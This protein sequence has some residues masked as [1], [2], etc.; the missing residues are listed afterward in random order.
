MSTSTLQQKK[1]GLNSKDICTI[2]GVLIIYLFGYICPSFGGIT[3]LGMKMLGVLIGLIFMTCTN[4]NIIV[5]SLFALLAFVLHG[6]YNAATLVSTWVGSTTTFQLVF[7][8]ALCVA[9][10]ESGAMDVVAKKMLTSKIAKGRP[11]MLML[12]IMLAGFCVS[13][14]IGGAPFFLLFFG[15]LDSV[16]SVAGYTKNDRFVKYALLGVYVSCY[17]MFLLPWRGAM[18][19]TVAMFN[20][21]LNPYGFQFVDWQYMVIQ[22]VTWVGFDIIYMLALKFI[23]RVDMS[24]LKTV[25]MTKVESFQKVP[26]KMD[27]QMKVTIGSLLFCVVYVLATSFIPKDAPGFAIYGSLGATLI[28]LVPL[29]IFACLRRNGKPILNIADLA[30]KSSLWSMIA[31]VGSLTM[32]GK[33]CTDTELGIRGWMVGVFTPLFGNMSIWLLLLIAVVFTTVITQLVN[34][35]VLTMGITPVIGPIVCEMILEQGVVANP[36]VAL[37]VVSSCASV[38]YMTVSGSVNAAYLLNRDEIKQKFLLTAGGGVL[39]IYM[40]WQYLVALG[41]NFIFPA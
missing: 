31:L 38:A 27:F 13:I 40:L 21:V 4:C 18:A 16:T 32:L 33:I 39:C 15:L 34:G 11:M 19:V 24:K 1:S 10:R 8:G 5:S 37:T 2:I 14:F 17:G 12:M 30:Q 25:D 23:F 22:I 3:P 29:L 36:T 6:Y 41:A 35:Q 7:C 28:W 20:S 9:L 26:D